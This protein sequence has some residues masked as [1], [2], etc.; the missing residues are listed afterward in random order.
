MFARLRYHRRV[1]CAFYLTQVQHEKLNTAFTSMHKKFITKQSEGN[2]CLQTSAFT[3]W[4]LQCKGY[5][6][7]LRHC[8]EQFMCGAQQKLVC[9]GCGGLNMKIRRMLQS[10]CRQMKP[11]P[12]F[13]F[14]FCWW[15]APCCNSAED[16][17]PTRL[18]KRPPFFCL[19]TR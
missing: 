19:L 5:E 16:S 10:Y 6:R 18:A 11:H 7:F 8:I 3:V 9:F 1:K 15:K 17:Q 2:F 12:D 4:W 13:S 14:P